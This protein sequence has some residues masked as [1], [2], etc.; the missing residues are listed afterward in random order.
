MTIHDESVDGEEECVRCP[1]C[2]AD[3][4]AGCEHVVAVIDDT[5]EEGPDGYVYEYIPAF[6]QEITKVF[7]ERLISGETAEWDNDYVNNLWT[8]LEVEDDFSLP[9]KEFNELVVELLEEAGG[10]SHFGT[11]ISEFGG[12]C[13][14]EVSIMYDENPEKLCDLAAKV[15]TKWLAAKPR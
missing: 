6:T 8:A 7:R 3:T 2:H 1:V 11:L 13:E 12:R 15:L 4:D 14:S 9:S 10:V 5:F